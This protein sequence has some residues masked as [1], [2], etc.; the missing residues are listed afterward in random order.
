MNLNQMPD[1]EIPYIT[2]STVYP[3]AGPKEIEGQITKKIEDAVST[4]S[5]IEK[6]ES[7]SLDGVSIIVIEFKLS[8]DVNVANQ[9]VK[10][11]V[12]EVDFQINISFRRSKSNFIFSFRIGNRKSHNCI[13]SLFFNRY[14][15][16]RNS[17]SIGIGDFSGHHRLGVRNNYK[18]AREDQSRKMFHEVFFK[19]S[20][21]FR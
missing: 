1:V 21:E 19:I 7:Y 6:I 14:T 8:K 18:E 12:D 3:G 5:E 13:F 20:I 16:T 11:K 9:E 15:C 10:S 2:I 17:L 4:V